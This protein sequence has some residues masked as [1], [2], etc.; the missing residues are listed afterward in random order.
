MKEIKAYSCIQYL[1][2]LNLHQRKSRIF[3]KVTAFYHKVFAV[4]GGK[5]KIE[6][7]SI[8]S[9]STQLS[10]PSALQTYRDYISQNSLATR[11]PGNCSS[12]ASGR[13]QVRKAGGG[14]KLLE[15]AWILKINKYDDNKRSF[16]SARN[17]IL[18]IA[19]NSPNVT[20]VKT[21]GKLTP[22]P[23]SRAQVMS[24]RLQSGRSLQR[25]REV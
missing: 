9:F 12:E 8:T 15:S 25:T 7:S 14:I 5:R 18:R 3:G 16:A 24:D 21:W 22:P 19:W 23:A 4:S 17:H 13:Y 20:G 11:I 2:V 10:K 1:P 6:K